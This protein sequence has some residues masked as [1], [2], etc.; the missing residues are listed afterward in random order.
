[1]SFGYSVGDVIAIGAYAWNLYRSCKEAPESFN[2]IAS[3]VLSLHAIIKEAE[4]TVFKVPLS[5][6]RQERL[7][8]IGDGCTD[9]L[10]DLQALVDKYKSLGT[11]RK[12]TWDRLR[13]RADEVTELRARLTA[14]AVLFTAYIR[15]V[16]I[17]KCYSYF[18]I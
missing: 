3:E 18:E 5:P 17:L 4:E 9:V 2:N 12:K 13:W 11:T 14:N 10:K 16:D 8:A 15:C 6:V 1:M 7:K